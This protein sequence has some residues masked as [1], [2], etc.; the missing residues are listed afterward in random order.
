[1]SERD[2]YIAIMVA[3]AHGKGLH[4]SADEVAGLSLDNAIAAAAAN[5]L[6]ASEWPEHR[7]FGE[8]NWKAIDPRRKR[9]PGN[10]GCIAPEEAKP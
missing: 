6:E 9:T 4:L 1:M 10:I 5:G 8:P 7:K 2:P 3:A